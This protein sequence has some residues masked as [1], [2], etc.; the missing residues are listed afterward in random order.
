MIDTQVLGSLYEGRI[1]T[2]ASLG[3]DELLPRCKTFHKLFDV[4]RKSATGLMGQF[5]MSL[6]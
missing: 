3:Q 2:E 4:L 5:Y 6:I 1:A